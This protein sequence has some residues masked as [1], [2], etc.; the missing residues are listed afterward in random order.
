MKIFILLFSVVWQIETFNVFT[1]SEYPLTYFNIFH[2][3]TRTSF[4]GRCIF[5]S[6]LNDSLAIQETERRLRSL[7]V[8]REV[9]ARKIGDTVYLSLWDAFTL[10]A[11]IDY[12]FY[13]TLREITFGVKEDNL[14]GTLSKISFY[15]F[16]KRERDYFQGGLLIPAF[17]DKGMDLSILIQRGPNLRKDMIMLNPFIS[18]LMNKYFN[19]LFIRQKKEEFLYKEGR[20]FDTSFVDYSLSYIKFGRTIKKKYT[21]VPYVAVEYLKTKDTV[22]K[23]FGGGIY[24]V[25]LNTLKSRLLR[26]SLYDDYLPSGIVSRVELYPLLA[27]SKRFSLYLNFKRG[28]K[29]AYFDGTLIYSLSQGSGYVKWKNKIYLKI[30]ERFTLFGYTDFG[31]IHKVVEPIS[32]EDILVFS[33]GANNGMYAY[34]P[35]YFNGRQMVFLYGE[36]RFFGPSYKRLL[37]LG[38]ALFY[39]LGNAAESI[40]YLNRSFGISLRLEAGMFGPSAIY[41]LNL[42][43][44]NFS[45][46]PIISFGTTLDFQ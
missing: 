36:L 6:D 25:K 46:P 3:K 4:V 37:G 29:G 12:K 42:G 27:N 24:Y 10:S 35:N 14:L 34:L 26:R 19:V 18:P 1:E 39:A 2:Y 20:V 9:K 45:T 15:Y 7:G 8:F 11:F 31:V 30:F 23:R 21:F 38:S 41:S 32:F 44:R 13:D 17:F 16:K 33:L 28:G 43:Y 5:Y 22:F 40:R